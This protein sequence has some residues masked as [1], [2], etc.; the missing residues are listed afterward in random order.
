MYLL[1]HM[2]KLIL[3]LVML[4]TLPAFAGY[5]SDGTDRGLC[6]RAG[7]SSSSDDGTVLYRVTET[8]GNL[9]IESLGERIQSPATGPLDADAAHCWG[10]AL[11]N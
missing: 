4:S 2:K 10:P 1:P 7:F 9:V 6:A 11:A 3:A 5:R 8:D